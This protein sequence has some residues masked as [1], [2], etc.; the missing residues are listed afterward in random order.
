MNYLLKQNIELIQ[1]HLFMYNKV[2]E[3]LFTSCIWELKF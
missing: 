2:K 1:F 3:K